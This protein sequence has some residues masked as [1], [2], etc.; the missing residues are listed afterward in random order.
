V[1]VRDVGPD[2]TK[3]SAAFTSDQQPADLVLVGHGSRDPGAGEVLRG[4][5]DA[6]A[7]ELHPLRVVLAWIE[8][9]SP[10]VTEVVPL[11][12]SDQDASRPVV[13][14]LLLSRGTHVARDLPEGARPPLGPDS[15]LTQI[16][17]DRIREAGIAPGRPLVLAATG[18]TDPDGT[19]DVKRQ[20]ELLE[21]A[22]G[23]P[24][25]MGFVTGLPSVADAV[26]Q[27]EE[28]PAIVSYFLAP[29]RL[30]D[31]AGCETAHL[32]THPGLVHLVVARYS[33][34][35]PDGVTQMGL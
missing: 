29:G 30:P 27:C 23:A 11:A 5:R 17:L 31:T 14:P 19:A 6:V 8:L 4:L 15:R 32:G 10:L 21:T 9:D 12:A 28:P 26:N 16:L 7:K 33:G 20:A 13:V 35:A 1:A 2:R 22:W 18:S 34:A 24:V 3:W 25:R